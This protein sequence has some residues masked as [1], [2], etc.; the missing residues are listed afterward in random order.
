MEALYYKQRGTAQVSFLLK[1]LS[2]VFET[3]KFDEIVQ[4]EGLGHQNAY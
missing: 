3:G 2:F 4:R 1:F